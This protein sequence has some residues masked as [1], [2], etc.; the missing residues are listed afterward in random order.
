MVVI[1]YQYD[2]FTRLPVE[3]A[4]D[5]ESGTVAVVV[6]KYKND[7]RDITAKVAR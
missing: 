1:T 5:G 7:I 6:L 2:V 3:R 4:C